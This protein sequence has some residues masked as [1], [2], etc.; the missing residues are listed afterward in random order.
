[1]ENGADTGIANGSNMERYNEVDLYLAFKKLI[2]CGYTF[3]GG[4]FVKIDFSL[5]CSKRKEFAL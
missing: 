4:N 5:V 2:L 3:K 1:M